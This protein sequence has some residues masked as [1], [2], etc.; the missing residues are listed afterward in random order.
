MSNLASYKLKKMQQL[1]SQLERSSR[2]VDTIDSINQMKGGTSFQ[3]LNNMIT[4]MSSN[5]DSQAQEVTGEF[6]IS[7]SQLESVKSFIEQSKSA[8]SELV[9]LAKKSA[10]SQGGKQY[11]EVPK[12]FM[13][14]L[15]L[16]TTLM[17]VESPTSEVQTAPAAQ[18]QGQTLKSASAPAKVTSGTAKQD[19][20]TAPKPAARPTSPAAKKTSPKPAPRPASPAKQTAQPKSPAKKTS[21]KS[22]KKSTSSATQTPTSSSSKKSTSSKKSKAKKG[23][24]T[25]YENWGWWD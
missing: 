5:L 6:V 12:D 22:S 1:E 11:K 14:T 25:K 9:T 21:T 3:E 19:S 18:T 15:G 17:G 23:T 24:K 8:I 7:E 20:A 4:D 2:L 10:M 16:P 13:D